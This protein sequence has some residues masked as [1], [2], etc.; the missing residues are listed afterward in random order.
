MI[1]KN[2]ES[3]ARIKKLELKCADA[4]AKLLS[5]DG[6]VDDLKRMNE[7]LVAQK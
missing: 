6:I 1:A 4:N 3:A 7:S 5:H 2:A